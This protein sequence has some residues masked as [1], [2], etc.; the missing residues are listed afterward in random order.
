MT[1][2]IPLFLKANSAGM[3]TAYELPFLKVRRGMG[4]HATLRWII[5]TYPVIILSSFGDNWKYL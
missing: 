3:R 2:S 4:Q 1:G 5:D